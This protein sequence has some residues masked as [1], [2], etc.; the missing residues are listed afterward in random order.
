MTAARL[1]QPS[2]ANTPRMKPDCRRTCMGLYAFVE[3]KVWGEKLDARM[4]A[5]IMEISCERPVRAIYLL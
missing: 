4:L 2:S 3:D 1:Y 5:N